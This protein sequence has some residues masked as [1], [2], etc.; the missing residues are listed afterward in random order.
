MYFVSHGGEAFP[1]LEIVLQGY[2]FTIDLVASTFISKAGIT[3]K[4]LPH[5]PR[6]TRH[7]LRN[8]TA[9]G[10]ILSPR[11]ERQPLHGHEDRD[12]QEEGHVKVKG[13]KKTVTR[14]IKQTVAGSLTM[15]TEF[16]GQNG[17]EIHQ[18]TPISVTGC[19]KGVHPKKAKSKKGG[20]KKK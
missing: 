14:N 8:H 16:I 11:G 15:P 4:H 18:N 3:L 19:P 13:H 12:G 17:A 2:G 10:Q 6:P 1:S 9:R 7:E 5:R 20:K